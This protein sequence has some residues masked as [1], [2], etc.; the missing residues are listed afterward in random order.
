M[1]SLIWFEG[2]RVSEDK[3]L[4]IIWQ[5]DRQT[6]LVITLLLIDTA[7]NKRPW[8][9]HPYFHNQK[10]HSFFLQHA[11]HWSSFIRLFHH[12]LVNQETWWNEVKAYIKQF[13][14]V[15]CREW[16]REKNSDLRKHIQL[17][18]ESKTQNNV[19]LATTC[20]FISIV[21][22]VLF[23]AAKIATQP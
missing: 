13:S 17:S 11:G 2:E 3:V 9:V 15:L 4:F 10:V 12:A 19:P 5:F 23:W 6:F 16:E 7:F 1:S 8:H 21:C 14:T 18:V 22:P 20:T